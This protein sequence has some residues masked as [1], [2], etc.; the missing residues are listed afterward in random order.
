MSLDKRAVV[1]A[2]RSELSRAL[3]T[4][5]A[6]AQTAREAAT[7]EEMKPENDKDTRSLEA[8]YLAGAQAARAKELQRAL[9]VLDALPLG[10]KSRVEAGALVAV[11]DP[12]TRRRSTLF[13]AP[14]GG[15]LRVVVDG[16]EV[17]VVTLESPLGDALAGQAAA[18][19]VEVERGGR[20]ELLEIVA[21]S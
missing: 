10:A 19:E 11:R 18:D 3:T 2:I 16:T 1:V 8:G 12:A 14:A 13:I 15:G 5:V 9:Q 4:M 20:T 7:H 6:A 17:Q 21:V